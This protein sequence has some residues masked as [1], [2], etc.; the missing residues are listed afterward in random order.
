MPITLSPDLLKAL[1][2]Q[3]AL[4]QFNGMSYQSL[5][6]AARADGFEGFAKYFKN[7]A[8]DEFGHAQNWLKYIARYN[9]RSDGFH[10]QDATIAAKTIPEMVQQAAELEAATE[11]SMR[12]VLTIAEGA[13]DGAAVEWVSG[14]LLDQQKMRKQADDFAARVRDAANEPGCLAIMD[15][16]LERG[17]WK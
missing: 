3:A 7:E 13:G 8:M 1:A 11:E 2:M 12:Q 4:E 6:Q 9:V 14:K 15:R 17:V 10:V 16:K 5:Y